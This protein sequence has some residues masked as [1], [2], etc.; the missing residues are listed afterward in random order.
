MNSRF[1]D[2]EI[3]DTDVILTTKTSDQVRIL[4]SQLVNSTNFTNA[5]FD[6][7]NSSYFGKHFDASM[8][9]PF[10]VGNGRESVPNL[11]ESM[12]SALRQDHFDTTQNEGDQTA[13]QMIDAP[14]QILNEDEV[15]E[16]MFIFPDRAR[17]GQ[18]EPGV[19]AGMN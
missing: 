10:V 18:T 14:D 11:A 3:R 19:E 16:E 5:N 8:Q 12:N 2:T 13:E 4:I 7:G 1:D 15:D 9:R 6:M 17:Q